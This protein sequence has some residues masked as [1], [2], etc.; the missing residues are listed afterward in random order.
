MAAQQD[1]AQ[2]DVN[3]K[4]CAVA[5]VRKLVQEGTCSFLRIREFLR[6]Y[7]RRQY[8]ATGWVLVQLPRV[9]GLVSCFFGFQ[10]ILCFHLVAQYHKTRAYYDRSGR[11]AGL[12]RQLPPS[13]AKR[14]DSL[15]A[16]SITTLLWCSKQ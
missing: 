15:V 16:C 8:P 1:T 4:L 10:N 13:L 5:H 12:T 11:A 2:R 9:A 3:T 6:K 14:L 7:G